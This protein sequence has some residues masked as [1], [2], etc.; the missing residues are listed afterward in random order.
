[1][2]CP[3]TIY[4]TE[5][6]IEVNDNNLRYMT[7]SSGGWQTFT[8]REEERQGYGRAHIDQ[9]YG[10]IDWIEG[11]DDDYRGQAK[12]GFAALEVMMAVYESARCH[13]R[14][15]LPLLTRANPLDER[16]ALGRGEG[17]SWGK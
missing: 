12:Y 10:I 14:V 1:V 13:E 3:A 17:M 7:S 2:E 6:I 5:G 4:G 9:A 8:P 15:H 11:R 16:A